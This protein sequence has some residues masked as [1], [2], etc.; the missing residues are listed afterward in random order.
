MH[1]QCY[2]WL[3]SGYSY[4]RQSTVAYGKIRDFLRGSRRRESLVDV[5][6]PVKEA[7]NPI[8]RQV[9]FL[10]FLAYQQYTH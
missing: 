9:V 10:F 2:A 7:N 3:D 8:W 5:F 6:G 4:M 1:F